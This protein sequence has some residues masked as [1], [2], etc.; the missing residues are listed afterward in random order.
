MKRKICILTHPLHIN[1]G[2]LLQAYALQKVLKDLGHDVVTDKRPQKYSLYRKF[3]T[4]CKHITYK[5]YTLCK[6]TICS[7]S[8][9][10]KDDCLLPFFE[11]LSDH[12]TI[13]KNTEDFIQKNILNIDFFAGKIMPAKAHIDK[14]DT[15]V[16][17]SD[18]V[19]R[20]KYSYNSNYFLNFISDDLSKRKVAYAA[21]FGTSDWEFSADQTKHA[22]ELAPLFDAISVRE[23][24]AVQLCE[25]YLG[26]NAIQV[27]DPTLLLS[28][29]DYITLVS[30]DEIAQS[31]GNLMTY[32]LDQSLDKIEII[33]KVARSLSLHPF[34]LMPEPYLGKQNRK[35]I[36]KCIYPKVTEWLR[37]FMDAEFVVTDSFHGTVFSILFNKPFIAIANKGRGVTR[38]T[39]LLKL[40]GLEDRL[41]YSMNELTEELIHKPIDFSQ[42]NAICEKEKKKSI[43]FLNDALK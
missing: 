31:K 41:V 13:I 1:Y 14:F 30:K 26:V 11:S 34:K 8:L 24:S 33:D 22:R 38:F 7:L 20:P 35:N 25:Q 32:V 39:S 6:R 4:L 15:F 10:R 3:R 2:G 40:F 23:D 42:V 18:Q 36:E 28:K 16:V 43:D 37:G 19:W 17:G 12:T 21:S 9:L 5:F 29:E 27:V